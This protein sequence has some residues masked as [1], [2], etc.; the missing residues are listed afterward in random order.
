MTGKEINCYH[1]A[2]TM[3][4]L[5]YIGSFLTDSSW[6]AI[7]ITTQ[8]G[9]PSLFSATQGGYSLTYQ[10]V[11]SI[12]IHSKFNISK[13]DKISRMLFGVYSISFGDIKKCLAKAI[14]I[15]P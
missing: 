9:N 1:S 8:F 13:V 4:W 10:D 2:M 5:G 6:Q 3:L 7:F 15:Q 12:L 14:W 11:L